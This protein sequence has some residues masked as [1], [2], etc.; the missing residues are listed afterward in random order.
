MCMTSDMN[1]LPAL[2]YQIGYYLPLHDIV[3][4][5]CALVNASVTDTR[6]A[7]SVVMGMVAAEK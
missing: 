4:L 5:H 2:S 3:V 7:A 6:V 1:I